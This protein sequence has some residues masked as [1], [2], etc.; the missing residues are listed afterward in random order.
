MYSPVRDWSCDLCLLTNEGGTTICSWCSADRT[1]PNIKKLGEAYSPMILQGQE[2]AKELQAKLKSLE[3]KYHDQAQRQ[4]EQA[5]IQEQ[6]LASLQT[7]YQAQAARQ[8]ALASLHQ[9]QLESLRDK[10]A[11]Q[12]ADVQ[13]RILER[14]EHVKSLGKVFETSLHHVVCL[15]EFPKDRHP[16]WYLPRSILALAEYLAS[17][18]LKQDNL[19]STPGSKPELRRLVQAMDDHEFKQSTKTTLEKLKSRSEFYHVV[20]VDCP[21]ELS[22]KSYSPQVLASVFRTFWAKLPEPLI[23]FHLYQNLI[24]LT[25][26]SEVITLLYDRENGLPQPQRSILE[27][28]MDFLATVSLHSEANR[29]TTQLLSSQF[30][31]LLIR[32]PSEQVSLEAAQV[33]GGKDREVEALAQVLGHLISHQAGVRALEIAGR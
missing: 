22:F 17:V 10:Y 26:R 23:P 20:A 1:N 15:H 21:I 30:A 12:D 6:A 4:L 28:L 2:A 18:C 31:P 3:K 19:F 24:V 29:G 8:A 7:K 9:A 33:L 25:Q 5:Q 16:S 13:R 11:N 27:A 32:A 14:E